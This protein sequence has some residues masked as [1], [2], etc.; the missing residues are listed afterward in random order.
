MTWEGV[1]DD[2]TLERCRAYLCTLARLRLP[3][4]LQGKLDPSDVVQQTLLTMGTTEVLELA[5][6]GV[7][8]GLAKRGLPGVRVASLSSLV[9]RA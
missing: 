6:S 9:G 1:V 4:R 3:S 7:L 8:S 5:P 2:A